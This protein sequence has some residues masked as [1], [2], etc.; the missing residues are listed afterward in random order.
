MLKQFAILFDDY[1][2]NNP[3]SFTAGDYLNINLPYILL[4]TIMIPGNMNRTNHTLFYHRLYNK[5][6]FQLAHMK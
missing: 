2:S 3:L 4:S 5:H 6:K 1:I